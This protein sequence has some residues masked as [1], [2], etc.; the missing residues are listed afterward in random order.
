MKQQQKPVSLKS[1]LP[2][3]LKKQFTVIIL[4]RPDPWVQDFSGAWV[5][6]GHGGHWG[7]APT[8][9]RGDLKGK[10]SP[11]RAVNYSKLHFSRDT[12]VSWKNS[13]DLRTG[14]QNERCGF[15]SWLLRADRVW[16]VTSTILPTVSR[17]IF[18]APEAS[19]RRKSRGQTGDLLHIWSEGLGGEKEV[20][21]K[22]FRR[23]IN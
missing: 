19:K 12:T 1:H 7:C 5:I 21:R 6:K 10:V 11:H 2:M 16:Y 15:E 8:Y 4:F 18:C 14:A 22:P 20:K 17:H 9:A 23:H 13:N 3:S